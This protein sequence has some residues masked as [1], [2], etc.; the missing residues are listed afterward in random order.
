[1]LV[2]ACTPTNNA[3][4]AATPA[5]PA[6]TPANE[7]AAPADEPGEWLPNN[8]NAA[9]IRMSWWGADPRHEALIAALD[10]YMDRYPH[11]T[12]D[13]EFG[14]FQGW[15]DNMV[16]QLAGQV[17]PDI[18]QVN[19]AWVHAFGGGTNVF[20][21]LNTVSNVLDLSEWSPELLNFMTTADG[22]LGA[23]PHGVTGRV[24]IYD[25]EMLAEH[26]LSSFPA[27]FDEWIEL[28]SSV[29]VGNAGLDQGNNTYAFY[30]LGPET[31]DVMFLQMLYNNTGKNMEENGQM[32]HTVEEVREIFEIIG[33]MTESGAMPTFEQQEPPHDATNPVW[34]EGRGGSAFEWVG[35]IFLAGGNFM[36]NDLDR[37]GIANLPAVAPGGGQAIMQRPSLGHAISR[38]SDYP[39]VAAHLLNF[40]YTDE[41]ALLIIAHHL[42]VPFS[43]TAA[44]IAERD[45]IIQ[46]LQ[47]EGVDLLINNHGIMS[48][49][50][51]DPN[52]RQPRFS[53][54]EAF[55][56]GS[57]DAETAAERFLSE[58]QSALDNMR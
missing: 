57:I 55:R 14:A 45:E 24:V 43:R 35:N 58:Q 39:E 44:A 37:L 18:M 38:N 46:G 1:M 29:S 36:E 11:I 53:I 20:L 6:A 52:L 28:G 23:V 12:V 3:A 30:P 16:I 13:H 17:E 10:L 41:E 33:R 32:L 50:F 4:P 22:Q 15:M 47:L 49:L 7:P 26:D 25:R 40:L 19:Y 8:G 31:I 48:P 5:A 21:D 27:T 2:S 9:T 34:M 42:G 56:T 54:F 51:E